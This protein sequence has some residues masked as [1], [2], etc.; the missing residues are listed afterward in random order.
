MNYCFVYVLQSWFLLL[1]TKATTLSVTIPGRKQVFQSSVEAVGAIFLHGI[2]LV[3][4]ALL[5]LGF[6]SPVLDYLHLLP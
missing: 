2:L 3:P 6:S 4:Q 1:I 5:S